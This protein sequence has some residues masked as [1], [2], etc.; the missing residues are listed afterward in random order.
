MQLHLWTST[1]EFTLSSPLKET[2]LF[3]TSVDAAAFYE[4]DE[5]VGRINYKQPFEVPPGI[6]QTP[7]LPVDLALGSVGY[8]AL[9]KA[10][11]QE[12][13]LDAVARVGVKVERYRDEVFYR[14]KGIAA[15]VRV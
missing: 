6:S 1:A 11:G 7:R 10:L 2:S 12:L 4:D 9:R 15:K 3:I 13:E 8:E 14:G 5:P